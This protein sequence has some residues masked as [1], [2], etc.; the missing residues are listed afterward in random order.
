MYLVRM[1]VSVKWHQQQFFCCHSIFLTFNLTSSASSAIPARLSMDRFA[2]L[3]NGIEKRRW[4]PTRCSECHLEI[5][6]LHRVFTPSS[7]RLHPVSTLSSLLS[8]PDKLL[9]PTPK[10]LHLFVKVI[11]I[12]HSFP[13][14]K[15]LTATISLVLIPFKSHLSKN[16]GQ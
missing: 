6:C 15:T 10:E 4:L 8:L 11:V 3:V 2:W 9:S 5:K 7:P 1:L 14:R 13:E 16:T 12:H